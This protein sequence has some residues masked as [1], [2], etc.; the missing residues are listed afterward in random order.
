M[1]C[2]KRALSFVAPTARTHTHTNVF[3]T[4]ASMN[5]EEAA[6]SR[7]YREL[8][9]ARSKQKLRQLEKDVLALKE[10]IHNYESDI[11]KSNKRQRE[12]ESERLSTTKK[13]NHLDGLGLLEDLLTNDDQDNERIDLTKPYNHLQ[14]QYGKYFYKI[15]TPK[16]LKIN[17]IK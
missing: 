17:L 3:G 15:L 9:L 16:N 5:T 12:F 6:E 14:E 1:T 8:E 4:R 13:Q 11:V 2:I 7:G 10:I